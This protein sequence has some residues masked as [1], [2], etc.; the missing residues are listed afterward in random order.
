MIRVYARAPDVCFS[1]HVY[2]ALYLPSRLEFYFT[3]TGPRQP[4][5]GAAAPRYA[6]LGGRP[7]SPLFGDSPA[8]GR[9]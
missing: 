6:S 4:D 7:P 2:V 8:P 9:G 3:Q 1:V 5:A